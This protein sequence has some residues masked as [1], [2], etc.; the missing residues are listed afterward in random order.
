MTAQ[1]TYDELAWLDAYRNA[2]REQCPDQVVKM[3]IFSHEGVIAEQHEFT[4]LN[5]LLVVKDDLTVKQTDQLC[6]LGYSLC[7]PPAT[8]PSIWTHTESEWKADRKYRGRAIGRMEKFGTPLD[9]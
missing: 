8:S 5:I 1:I 2:I 4:D 6:L 9:F 7:D 3:M